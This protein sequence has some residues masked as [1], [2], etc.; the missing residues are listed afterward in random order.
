MWWHLFRM[1]GTAAGGT[2]C[3]DFTVRPQPHIRGNVGPRGT[4]NDNCTRWRGARE[5]PKKDPR[6]R[7]LCFACLARARGACRIM[8]Q[9]LICGSRNLW[10]TAVDVVPLFDVLFETIDRFIKRA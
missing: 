9:L 10:R 5:R 3:S 6:A 1:C 7:R 4:Q 2:V 8:L